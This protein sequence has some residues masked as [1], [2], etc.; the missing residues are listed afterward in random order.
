MDRSLLANS[1]FF[2]SKSLTRIGWLCLALILGWSSSSLAAKTEKLKWDKGPVKTPYYFFVDGPEDPYMTRLRTE[3]GIDKMTANAKS[4]LE[5]IEIICQ[6]VHHQWPHKGDVPPPRNDPI[7]ILYEARR[8]ATFSCRE[9][10]LVAAGCLN[11]LGIKTRVVEIMP[12]NVEELTKGSYHIVAEAYLND[13]GRWAMLDP[14]WGVV[15]TLNGGP[16]NLVELQDAVHDGIPRGLKFVNLPD[17][18]SAI[19]AAG[20]ANYIYHLRVSFNNR[21][22]TTKIPFAVMG[23]RGLMLIPLDAKVSKEF[24][25]ATVGR[26]AVTRNPKEFYGTIQ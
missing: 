3:F 19:Y 26:V 10:S 2:Q 1:G 25:A 6:W 17:S 4:D 16:L 8:G 14:Q 23:R 5:R 20:M 9:Y 11:S 22:S 21:V 24:E 15:P 7:Q 12:E 13:L 18:L